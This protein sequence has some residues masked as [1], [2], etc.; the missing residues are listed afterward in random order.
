MEKK[1]G[2]WERLRGSSR[3]RG[4]GFLGVCA[5]ALSILAMGYGRS[6]DGAGISEAFNIH[7]DILCAFVVCFL[8]YGEIQGRESAERPSLSLSALLFFIGLTLLLDSLILFTDGVSALRE[9]SRA[10]SA[11]YYISIN[12][13]LFLFWRYAAQ[14]L[15]PGRK[16]SDLLALLQVV[17][18]GICLVI[19]VISYFRPILFSI[20]ENGVFC[21]EA[22]YPLGSVYI[23][24]VFCEVIRMTWGSPIGKLRKGFIT[25]LGGISVS[26]F[27]LTWS[28]LRLSLSY[29]VAVIAVTM[30]VSLLYTDVIRMK[31]LVIR[32]YSLL[33]LCAMLV[34]APHIYWS[35]LQEV[36]RQGYETARG[37]VVPVKQLLDEAGLEELTDIRNT[38]L[39]KSTR[40]KIRGIC[41]AFG[42][43]NLYVETVDPGTG[44]R[45]FILAVAASDEEDQLVRASLGWPGASIWVEGESFLLEP[46]LLALQGEETDLYSE[47]DN[48]YGHNLDWFFPY[49]DKEGK[50]AAVIGVDMEVSRQQELGIRDA[51]AGAMPVLMLYFATLFAQLVLLD[52]VFLQPVFRIAGHIR[53]FFRDGAKNG[54]ALAEGGSYEIRFLS[55]SFDQMVARLEEY[56]EN[57]VREAREKQRIA[58]ELEMASRLQAHSLPGKFPPFPERKE[59][60]LHASMKPAREVGGDFYDFFLIDEDHLALLTADVS[61]KGMAA[62]L[63]MM[64]AKTML[65]TEAQRGY[66]PAG[67]LEIVNGQLGE[68]NVDGMFVTVW[69]GILELSSGQLVFADAGHERLL[70]RQRGEWG[71]I[72]KETGTP[73]GIFPPLSVPDPMDPREYTNQRLRLS[74]GDMLFQ[75]TDGIPEAVNAKKEFFGEERLLETLR[76]IASDDPET[77]LGR[78]REKLDAFAAGAEQFDDITML[79][80][81]YSQTQ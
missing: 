28:D 30:A 13:L 27:I 60:L 22:G 18:F 68:G 44:R 2:L 10:V 72:P 41:R 19:C 34:Y 7:M 79:C 80:L 78:L 5:M 61:G 49:T 17:L 56:E 62:A 51:I 33:L 36:I 65:K 58:T 1:K 50:V 75:Y 39:Y 54:T 21:R 3:I 23:L 42:L 11:A 43:Q 16:R 6:Y 32:I 74:K 12:L 35:S 40:Q 55:D 29:T 37:V 52:S 69:L 20:D 47:Q 45:S 81:F 24:Y 53:H 8:Y 9:L 63:F 31:E 67:V 71:F 4:I 64:R 70:V 14:V 48:T 77:L 15:C 57:R 73:L 25:L 46:E 59:F 38:G 66:S 76:G 26:A